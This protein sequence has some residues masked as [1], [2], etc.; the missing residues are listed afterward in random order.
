[1]DRD[2]PGRPVFPAEKTS[3][4]GALETASPEVSPGEDASET[5]PQGA[6]PP[7][8]S[9]S[10]AIPARRALRPRSRCLQTPFVMVSTPFG[11]SGKHE[12]IFADVLFPDVATRVMF[13]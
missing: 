3:E 2:A 11:V 13:S 9:P 7:R 12:D 4:T 10:S 5:H 1:M 6:I 8:K